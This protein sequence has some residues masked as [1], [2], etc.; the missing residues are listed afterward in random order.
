MDNS[1][2]KKPDLK[3]QS[4][5]NNIQNFLNFEDDFAYVILAILPILTITYSFEAS[6]GMAIVIL[7]VS[8]LNMIVLSQL[9][10]I[11]PKPIELMMNGVI[12]LTTITITSM[13]L[14]AFIPKLYDIINGF[15]A[16]LLAN[17]IV[18]SKTYVIQQES[19]TKK[20]FQ[21]ALKFLIKL[22]MIVLILGLLREFLG[23]GMIVIGEILPLP[24]KVEFL[25][26]LDLSTYALD[27]FVR[28][29]GALVLIGVIYG[30]YRAIRNK[31]GMI[32]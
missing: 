4:I 18:L 6:I 12:I 26:S 30:F 13:L 1:Q 8:I 3:T 11:T 14:H 17:V 27:F 21:E 10:K 9:K 19:M 15:F 25:K 5:L 16:L 22:V 23:T 28:P 29:M 2:I 32:K 20:S 24:L 7:I 31:R